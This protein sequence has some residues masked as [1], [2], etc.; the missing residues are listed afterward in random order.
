MDL[1]GAEQKGKVVEGRTAGRISI[2]IAI[3]AGQSMRAMFVVLPR[4]RMGRFFS[5]TRG[6]SLE[7]TESKSNRG[8]WS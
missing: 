1:E 2:D 7:L 6:S 8:R 4:R 3:L 5:R